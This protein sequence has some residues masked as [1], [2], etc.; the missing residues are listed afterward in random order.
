M[1]LA[2]KNCIKH[3]LYIIFFFGT[4]FILILILVKKKH[5]NIK[6]LTFKSARTATV[7]VQDKIEPNNKAPVQV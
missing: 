4:K 5:I 6:V 7:S 1:N 2:L 3:K